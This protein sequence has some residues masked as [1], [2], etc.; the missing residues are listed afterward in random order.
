LSAASLAAG[1]H[2]SVASMASGRSRA[3]GV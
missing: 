1:I 3:T 2:F